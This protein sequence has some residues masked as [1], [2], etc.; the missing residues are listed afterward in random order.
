MLYTI[1][2]VRDLNEWMVAHLDGFPLFERIPD[3]ELV[4]DPILQQVKVSTEEGQKVERNE[5]L[6]LW[7]VYRRK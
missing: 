7:A 5:G 2:D 3:E 1:T 4:D 6:K